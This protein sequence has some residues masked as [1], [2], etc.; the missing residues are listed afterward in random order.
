AG[1]GRPAERGQLAD[2]DDDLAGEL[3]QAMGVVGQRRVHGASVGRA[4]T[5][6]TMLPMAGRNPPYDAASSAFRPNIRYAIQAST[7][8]PAAPSPH[9]TEDDANSSAHAT[10]AP[11][12]S[13][14]S[15]TVGRRA[16]VPS[17]RLRPAAA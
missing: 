7:T 12:P 1:R 6:R 8:I 13:R 16:R 4:S 3:A 11:T 9:G 17:T 14:R 10:R 15:R 2:V 5:R